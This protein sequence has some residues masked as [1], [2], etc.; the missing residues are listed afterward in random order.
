MK[1]DQFSFF[2]LVFC[3]FLGFDILREADFFS[4]LTPP[5]LNLSGQIFFRASRKLF[6]LSGQ[7][8]TL[9]LPLLVAGPLKK[10]AI[11]RLPLLSNI[12]NMERER[13][14]EKERTCPVPP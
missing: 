3:F 7:A 10:R 13:K 11:L 12:S 9:P 1:V 2:D 5:P 6:F 4:S 8:L 14:K